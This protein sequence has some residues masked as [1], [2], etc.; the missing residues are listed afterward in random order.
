M[1]KK[2]VFYSLVPLHDHFN[3]LFLS[4]SA[5]KLSPN[6]LSWRFFFTWSHGDSQRSQHDSAK[7]LRWSK[8]TRPWINF[9]LPDQQLLFWML[10]GFGNPILRSDWTVA[11]I[12]RSYSSFVNDQV[13]RG[14]CILVQIVMVLMSWMDGSFF[15]H[16]SM[17]ALD[18][19]LG[20]PENTCHC[21][22]DLCSL[23]I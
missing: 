17:G 7:P 10:S 11:S 5:V 9:R 15:P 1:R 13:S 22:L 2:S 4:V 16:A 3:L 14:V 6:K 19:N 23:G 8:P 18:Q 12:P 21:S 20:A